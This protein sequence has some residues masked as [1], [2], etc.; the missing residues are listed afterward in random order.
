LLVSVDRSRSVAE[1]EEL[2]TLLHEQHVHNDG[3]VVG[4]DFSGNP[5]LNRFT[6]YHALMERFRTLGKFITVHAA[7]VEDASNSS[8]TAGMSLECDSSAS[9]DCASTVHP[10]EFDSILSFGPQRLGHALYLQPRHVEGLLEM[11]RRFREQ[12]LNA[13]TT[14]TAWQRPPLIE[15]C[16]TS[17]RFTLNHTTYSEHP[18]LQTWLNSEYPIAISTDDSGVFS[19]SLSS[20]FL[21]VVGAFRLT[22]TATVNL[23][24]RPISF[25]FEPNRKLVAEMFAS[26]LWAIQS[27][28]MLILPQNVAILLQ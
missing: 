4:I 10:H 15:V 19:S 9:G 21:H 5:L 16:P 13:G 1:N 6:D 8:A 12:E 20:E 2:L 25:V 18:H 7:E 26:R 14:S 22:L 27:R 24:A 11:H 28:Q 3:I 17:N 23:A